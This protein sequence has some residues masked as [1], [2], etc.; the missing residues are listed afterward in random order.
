MTD[1]SNLIPNVPLDSMPYA[2][3]DQSP[4]VSPVLSEIAVSQFRLS[5]IQVYNWGTFSGQHTVFVPSGGLLLTGKSGSGKS[6]LLDAIS[7]VLMPQNQ[8]KF[9]AA[10]QDGGQG[11]RSRSLYSYLRGAFRHGQDEDSREVHT[12]F[13]R[14]GAVRAGILLNFV[15]QSNGSEVCLVCLF[16]LKSSATSNAEVSTAYFLAESDL[17]L[18]DLMPFMEKSL[19]SR[20]IVKHFPILTKHNSH[21]AFSAAFRRKLQI[22]SEVG[23]RLLHKTQ[24]AKSL[25]S[26][27]GL[28]RDFMLDE[29]KTFQQ[30]DQAVENFQELKEAHLTVV[31]ARKQEEVL[32]PL[33]AL[34]QRLRDTEKKIESIE[35]LTHFL[36]P[37]V[38]KRKVE[39]W[40]K[41][42][43]VARA[44]ILSAKSQAESLSVQLADA[45][46]ELDDLLA[47]QDGSELALRENLK[48]D[49]EHAQDKLEQ[50]QAFW[51]DHQNVLGLLDASTPSN[52]AE[53]ELLSELLEIQKTLAAKSLATTEQTFY[54]AWNTR[55]EIEK[56][57]RTVKD[58]ISQVEAS[59]SGMPADLSRARELIC[60]ACN[61]STSALFFAGEL[62]ELKESEAQWRLATESVCGS[63]AKTL[64]VPNAYYQQVANAVDKTNLA[65]RLSYVR[66]LPNH[67][68]WD[69]DQV[70][71]ERRLASKLLVREKVGGTLLPVETNEWLRLE[72]NQRFRHLCAQSVEEL[73]QAKMAVTKRGQIKTSQ[74]RHLKDDRRFLLDRRNWVV[75]ADP[76][77]RLESL[78][79]EKRQLQ[80]EL[81]QAQATLGRAETEKNL[82]SRNLR[83]LEGA[84]FSKPWKQVNVFGFTH[85]IENLNA[86][87]QA[88]DLQHP[89][90]ASLQGKIEQAKALVQQ[91]DK[92]CRQKE[93]EI[94][95]KKEDAKKIETELAN[96]SDL[97]QIPSEIEQVLNRYFKLE[98]RLLKT[99]DLER[100]ARKTADVLRKEKD[101]S[102]REQSNASG[103]AAR[104]MTRFKLTWPNL[105][106]D[107]REEI[108]FLPEF[109]QI[110]ARLQSDSLPKFEQRFRDLLHEQAGQNISRLAND[111]RRNLSQVRLRIDPVNQALARV[112]FS[113][114]RHL[115]ID[116]ED[117][118]LPAVKEFL[119]DLTQISE[120]S[121]S[122][123]RAKSSPS[124]DEA[125]FALLNRVMS[126]LSS[127]EA[128]DKSWRRQVLD[129]RTHVTFS[130]R[131]LDAS[132]QA[133]DFY[134]DA[135]GLSGGQ[136]QKLVVFALAAALRYQLS[137]LEHDSGTFSSYALV[138]LDE[139]FDKTDS[140]FTRAGLT[141][142]RDFGFQLL[143]ATPLTKLQTLEDFVGGVNL[144]SISEDGA[145]SLAS[146]TFKE[147]DQITEGI[148]DDA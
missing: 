114:G 148:V 6:S 95:I 36:E 92:S 51:D 39:L 26:L 122:T 101:A 103:D 115:W 69:D 10:A 117:R 17:D 41:D 105:A 75:G 125:R 60:R 86:R 29:P 97:T 135:S 89:Q 65:T 49:L 4:V 15:K 84:N 70:P 66:M 137:A 93:I 33:L 112:D 24:A 64:L 106:S 104:I 28:L 31:E 147:L 71:Q 12:K 40:L 100:S 67:P 139:A 80:S 7:T 38:Q 143:L 21:S 83:A 52:E 141:V 53:Y 9:N 98:K 109:L 30:A 44:E 61:I 118:G 45:Q 119:A 90:Q 56:K 25:N 63:F 138:V 127:S 27:D 94:G 46:A 68:Y 5:K 126:R 131:E 124:E 87:L 74:T 96:H 120:N 20:G 72:L 85:E 32:T 2:P 1:Y 133:V 73:V 14:E 55:S 128:A 8:V 50:A 35:Q 59:G 116:V 23:Q 91:L 54:Q 134:K 81:E 142:F 16:H 42:L 82:A 99:D 34:D 48:Q 76:V 110:L 145:S 107:V 22:P 3:S 43:K 19:D 123:T 13:L 144:V 129:T 121:L 108:E 88:F 77:T 58:E 111:I 102:Q 11:D 37:Y 79:R 57:L 62:F 130:A 146:I 18:I 47:Q 78:S 140:E 132:N 136:K 113:P